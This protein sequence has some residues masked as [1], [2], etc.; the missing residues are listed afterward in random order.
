MHAINSNGKCFKCKRSSENCLICG[1]KL[2]DDNTENLVCTICEPGYYLN[3]DGKCINYLNYM[4]R[5]P[6]C[7][8]YSYSFNDITY[9]IGS[10]FSSSF[11]KNSGVRYSSGYEDK[12]YYSIESNSYSYIKSNIGKKDF[13]V[14][15]I[16]STFKAKCIQC[17][18]EYYLNSEGE[19][20]EISD[21]DC[22]FVSI[23]Y[24]ITPKRLMMCEHFCWNINKIYYE[25][26]YYNTIEGKNELFKPQK[27]F[28][29]FYY[30]Y[31]QGKIDNYNKDI[32]YYINDDLKKIF[33][34]NKLCVE[35]PKNL[36]KFHNCKAFQYDASTDT[37]KCIE[38]N[39]N[40]YLDTKNNSCIF[41]YKEH[42]PDYYNCLAENI[43]TLSEP[44][45]SCTNCYDDNYLLVT[46][47]N[48]IKYCV[49]KDNSEI[50]YCTKANTD[51]TYVNTIY[52]CTDC[53]NNF[54]SYNSEFFGR[55]ICQNVFDKI[56]TEKEISL[57][58]FEGA[59]YI[60]A[61]ENGTCIKKNMFSPDGEKCYLCD[62][63][64]IGMPGCKGACNFSTK[65]ND[66]IICEDGCKTGYIEVKKGIC[67]PCNIANHGCY[68]CHYEDGDYP[69]NYP[70][71]K[72]ERK[73]ICDFCEPGFSK[74]DGKCVTCSGVRSV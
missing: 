63:Q 13:N 60:K 44:I 73:F 14:P 23:A 40:Y 25:I 4:E 19:C 18:S 6:N 70:K 24:D 21:E 3:I 35:P 42:K 9:C 71:I 49:Y 62:D 31:Y 1:F 41:T 33:L 43:G 7:E 74:I 32:F 15:I 54:L 16:N 45:F 28:N 11:C 27:F 65:R 68:E 48:N 29:D 46:N 39:D 61:S 55:K 30:N 36:G 51:T 26:N 47:E 34:K 64:N 72:R 5:I 67:E 53:S 37:Y 8:K 59:E 38:C 69:I 57:S 12:D 2:N 52:N 17:N 56:I 66:I 58:K 10:S 50:R 20:V 22:S